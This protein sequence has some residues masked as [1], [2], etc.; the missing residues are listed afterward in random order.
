MGQTNDVVRRIARRILNDIRVELG[1]EFDKNF[2]RKG[3]FGKAWGRRH[4]PVSGGKSGELLVDSGALRRSIG[5]RIGAD[6]MRIRFFSD[7]AYA[8]IH[9][10][11]GEIVVTA[12]MKRYFRYRFYRVQGGFIRKRGGGGARK[13]LTD[14]GFYAWTETMQLSDEAKFWRA[15]ALKKV[16][17]T[18]KIPQR[19]FLGGGADVERI[20]REIIDDNL[21]EYFSE[22]I[23]F[24]V[25]K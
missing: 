3:Y 9:N 2:E 1:D 20:V 18:I 4:S 10:E 11:G 5:S 15:L 16:G 13:P 6:G 23:N 21:G 22:E 24:R 19:Q 14:G 7:L 12:R 25:D 8:A 17:S